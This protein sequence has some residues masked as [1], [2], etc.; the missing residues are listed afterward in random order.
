MALEWMPRDNEL[1]N[2]LLHTDAT[3]DRP[4]REGAGRAVRGLD[5]AQ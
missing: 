5:P 2:H 1:K 4:Q 3:P